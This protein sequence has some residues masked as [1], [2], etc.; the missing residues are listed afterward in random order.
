[1]KLQNLKNNEL[2]TRQYTTNTETNYKSIPLLKAPSSAIPFLVQPYSLYVQIPYPTLVVS[3]C[4]RTYQPNYIVYYDCNI[5]TRQADTTESKP[6]SQQSNHILLKASPCWSGILGILA[7]HW[8]WILSKG[9]SLSSSER[10]LST[11]RGSFSTT[12]DELS[13]WQQDA[14]RSGP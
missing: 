4:T 13:V 2:K 8:K 3:T 10:C 7:H 5:C 14:S 11:L 6:I 12:S 9:L 1:M